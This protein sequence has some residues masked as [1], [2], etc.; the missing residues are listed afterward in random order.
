MEEST[1]NITA[2]ELQQELS[3]SYDER[4]KEDKTIVIKLIYGKKPEVTF[5]GFWT[6]KLINSA[7]NSIARAYRTYRAQAIRT[8][9][10]KK[11]SGDA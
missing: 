11:E 10:I 9:N 5:T 6:G 7:T 2:A 3:G 4:I 1:S 8:N